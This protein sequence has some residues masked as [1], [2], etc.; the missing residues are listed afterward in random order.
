M[1]AGTGKRII[2]SYSIGDDLHGPKECFATEA[3]G[4]NKRSRVA[5]RVGTP[6]PL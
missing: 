6:Q 2:D 4:M 1:A 5:H 3:I